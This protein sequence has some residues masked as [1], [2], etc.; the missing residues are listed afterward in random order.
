MKQ[1]KSNKSNKAKLFDINYLLFDVGKVIAMVPGFFWLRPKWIYENEN[2]KQRIRGGAILMVNHSGY[3]DPVLAQY[4]IWYRRQHFVATKELFGTKFRNRMFHNFH[5][6]AIDKENFNFGT[7][8]DITQHLDDGRVVSICPEGQINL[9]DENV[10][11]FKSGIVMMALRSGKPIV[12]L[13][14]VKPK[15]PFTRARLG[16]G[17]PINLQEKY[18]KLPSIDTIDKI[19]QELREHEIALSKLIC[20]DGEEYL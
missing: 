13:F 2:A 20:K 3:I 9:T 1:N 4:A 12:P 6:I 17:E 18:G 14:V 16:I 11:A 15:K 5:C 7:F 10:A 8:R 19:S